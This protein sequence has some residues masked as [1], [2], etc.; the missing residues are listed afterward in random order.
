ML[1]FRVSLAKELIDSYCNRK[2][3]AALPSLGHHQYNSVQITFRQKQLAS[4]ATIVT[5]VVTN[6]IPLFGIAMYA[7][8]LSASRVKKRVTAS[9]NTTTEPSNGN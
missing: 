2:R 5:T 3:Q 6:N 4:A 9:G 8:F 7:G 1:D